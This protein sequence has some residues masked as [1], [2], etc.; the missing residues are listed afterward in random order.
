MKK[1]GA[2]KLLI[3][4]RLVI[5]YYSGEITLEDIIY[6]KKQISKD[7]NYDFSF[8][9]LFDMRDAI[10]KVSESEMILLLEFLNKHFKKG[11][12][13][14]VAYLTNSPNDVVKSTLFSILLNNNELNMNTKIFSTINAIAKWFNIEDI[15]EKELDAILFRL[16]TQPNNVYE[17]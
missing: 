9:T 3:K 14:N 8:N 6:F 7:L 15:N 17:K 1:I 13:R 11:N 4:E 12:V 5:E 2:Y 16:K 10:I